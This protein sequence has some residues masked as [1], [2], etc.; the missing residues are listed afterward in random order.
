MWSLTINVPSGVQVMLLYENEAR[1]KAA[2]H[3]AQTH[4]C[5]F[6]GEADYLPR[7]PVV[8]TDDFGT[9]VSLGLFD[10]PSG[11]VILQ[12]VRRGLEGG[13]KR[14]LIQNEAQNKA[15][16]V[17]ARHAALAQPIIAPNGRMPLA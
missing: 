9:D 17:A 2:A 4:V 12:D 3:L 11:S 14:A 5:G 7:R 1:A 10:K 13:V 8:I 16:Q 15:N 6:N